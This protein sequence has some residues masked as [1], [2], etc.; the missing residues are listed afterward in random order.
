MVR[1]LVR[2]SSAARVVVHLHARI[3][4]KDAA[5]KYPIAVRNADVTLAVSRAVAKQVATQ[6]AI[7]VYSGVEIGNSV[8][9]VART[10]ECPT[11][12]GTASRLV[13]IKGVSDLIRAI[14]SLSS[15]FPRLRLEIA[16]E[17]PEL[18]NLQ[19]LAK[20]IQVIDRVRFLG[21][22]RDM[23]PVFKGWD[24]FAMASVTEGFPMAALEAMAQ[25]LPVVA[26]RVGG[27]PE[28]VEDGRTGY[29]VPP[30][31]P[32]ALACRLRTLIRDVDQRHEM[33]ALGLR[34]VRENFS[35]ERMNAQIADIY[36]SLTP[37]SGINR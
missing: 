37:E 5:R 22:Q 26:T 23:A 3:P 29:L 30:S 19:E 12:V 28:M 6:E 2:A 25:S 9:L 7:V 24:I 1:R 33:G 35:V 14:A 11:I 15:E 27:L 32:S 21:W 13:D 36:R 16:G 10:A 8:D 20:A 18:E 4:E 34:R 31:D 17:G